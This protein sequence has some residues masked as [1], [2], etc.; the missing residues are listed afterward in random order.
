MNLAE[1]ARAFGRD[2]STAA[3]AVHLI[4]DLRDDPELDRTIG[5]MEALLRSAAG[6]PL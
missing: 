1:I 6:M 5:W 3:H 4:E 2:R